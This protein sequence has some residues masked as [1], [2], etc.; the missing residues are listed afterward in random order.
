MDFCFFIKKKKKETKSLI[1]YHPSATLRYGKENQRDRSSAD[2]K[3][4]EFKRRRRGFHLNLSNL[5]LFFSE[6]HFESRRS[7]LL[8]NHSSILI[9]SFAF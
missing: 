4:C 6:P 8:L 5:S 2:R 1:L 7:H 9:T 3:K